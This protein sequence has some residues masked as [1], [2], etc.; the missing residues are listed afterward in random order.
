[1]Y[2]LSMHRYLPYTHI[3]IVLFFFFY[4]YSTHVNHNKQQIKDDIVEGSHY[5]TTQQVYLLYNIPICHI[6]TTYTTHR[7]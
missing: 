6:Q 7:Q 1:M 5:T 2:P 4:E 3:S